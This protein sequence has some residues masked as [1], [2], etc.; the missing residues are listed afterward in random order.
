M[1][2]KRRFRSAC[3]FAQSDQNLHGAHFCIA[4]DAKKIIR[5]TKTDQTPRMRMLNLVFVGRTCQNVRIR[6]LRL[7]LVSL[8]TLKR[9]SQQLSSALPSA[10]TLKV[11]AAN[12]VDPDQ[13][14]LGAV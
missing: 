2:A 4:K 6:T 11:I 8:L 10:G 13:T 14:A 1:C 3:A 5:T 7:F 9:Q 12:S